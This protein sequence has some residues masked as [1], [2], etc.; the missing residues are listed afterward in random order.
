M[1]DLAR[2]FA[3]LSPPGSGARARRRALRIKAE[4]DGLANH[5]CLFAFGQHP[6]RRE[7]TSEGYRIVYS[8]RPDTGLNETAG[9]VEVLRVFG[10]GQSRET[11]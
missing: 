8:V 6:G 1:R 11:L 2:A 5:P 3:W 9:D 4:I 7:F 10:P